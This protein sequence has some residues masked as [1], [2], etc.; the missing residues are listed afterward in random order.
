MIILTPFRN[1]CLTGRQEVG[2]LGHRSKE[3]A[4]ICLQ[5]CPLLEDLGEWSQWNLVFEPE[6]GNL[7]DF[8]QKYGSVKVLNLS[9]NCQKLTFGA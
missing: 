6:L 5:N 3:Q 8:I 1:P 7:K 9:G 2:I 4:L